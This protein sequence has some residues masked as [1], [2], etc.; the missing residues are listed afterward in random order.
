MDHED[1]RLLDELRPLYALPAE[2]LDGIGTVRKVGDGQ[3]LEGG[4]AGELL[5]AAAGRVIPVREGAGERAPAAGLLVAGLLEGGGVEQVPARH[6]VRERVVVDVFVVFV[7]P[8]DPVDVRRSVG[9]DADA[10]RPVA[11]RLAHELTAGGE[12][13]PIAAPGLVPCHRPGDIGGD[14][15]L[16]LAG[17]DPDE[18]AA[19]IR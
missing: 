1:V 5:V 19:R 10:R 2:H 17:Q 18:L 6:R 11:R 8:D 16:L 9:V 15:L 3:P 12:H 7:G 14:V 13:L 4:V